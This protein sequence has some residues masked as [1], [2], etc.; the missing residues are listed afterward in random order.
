MS[1]N[2]VSPIKDTR[3][4]NRMKAIL[5]EQNL[6]DWLLMTLGLNTALR[7]SD[8][9]AIR[10][11][12]VM[13]PDTGKVKETFSLKEKK[14]SKA[15]TIYIN[16]ALRKALKESFQAGIF[17]GSEWLFPS[18]R[19]PQKPLSRQQCHNNLTKAAQLAGIKEPISTHSLRKTTGYHL[20]KKGTP[21][22]VIMKL[23][24]H[25]SQANTLRYL[26]IE[27]EDINNVYAGLNL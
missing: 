9:L 14:T 13:D 17:N 10:V 24:N 11:A 12:D 16:T 1:M 25:S 7:I 5:K 6:R 4:L 8:L 18:P 15:K 20:Y 26:G 21:I 3:K 27:Q 23:L 2:T 19:N 22:A